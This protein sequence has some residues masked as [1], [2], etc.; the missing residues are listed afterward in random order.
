[1]SGVTH[2]LIDR[3]RSLA[4]DDLPRDVVLAAKTCVLDWFGCALAG[5]RE[6]LTRIL[7]AEADSD[8][9]VHLIGSEGKTSAY[10]ATLVN[11]AAGHALDYDDTHLHMSGHPSAPVAPA[12]LALAEEL[13]KS[14]R[15]VVTAFVA[16]VETECRL[17][18]VMG[19]GHYSI[20]WHATGTMGTFGAA[21]ACAHVLGLDEEAWRHAFG[22]AGTQAS[23]L[24]AVF[25]TMSKPLHA[26]KAAQNGLLAAKLAGRGFTSNTDIVDAHQGFAATHTSTFAPDV[27]GPLEGRWLVTETLFKYHASCYLTHSAMEAAI[28]LVERHKIDP[29]DVESA[30]VLVPPGHLDVCGISEPH[31]GLEGKFSLRA[32]VAMALLGDD[33]ADPGAFTDDRITSS[34]LVGLRDRIEVVPTSEMFGT[35]TTVEIRKRDGTDLA[36][37]ADVGTPATDLER[38]WER[39]TQKF[40]RLAAPVLGEDRA[41][42][43]HDRVRSLDELDD[44]AVLQA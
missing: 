21:A 25:G 12:V 33:T 15:D 27:L 11:G 8:G 17:G 9:P 43:L 41:W 3:A 40:V 42:S 26:G 28:G 18:A 24:K 20:G 22:I 16:G 29:A 32:T 34:E 35:Q 6:P 38:Q 14:G 2:Q 23:G 37:T 1:V 5:S 39:L 44:T 31:S 36:D 19:P 30:R 10:W 13:H 7:A 4:F